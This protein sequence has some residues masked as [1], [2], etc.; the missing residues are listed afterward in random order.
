M[1]RFDIKKTGSQNAGA[2]RSRM[3]VSSHPQPALGLG[4]GWWSVRQSFVVRGSAASD[5]GSY[6]EKRQR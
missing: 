2:V 3:A 6:N 5:G 1:T 4:L